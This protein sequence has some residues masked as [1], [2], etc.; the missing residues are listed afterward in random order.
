MKSRLLQISLL[1]LFP[2]CMMAQGEE[3]SILKG[4]CMPEVA[5]SGGDSRPSR[6][7]GSYHR[8]GCHEDL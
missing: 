2:L 3:F 6:R 8:M 1:L 4:D 5:A 7:A